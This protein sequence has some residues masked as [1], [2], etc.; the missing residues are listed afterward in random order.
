MATIPFLLPAQAKNAK[1]LSIHGER[2]FPQNLKFV[3]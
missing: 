3:L 1:D 2:V